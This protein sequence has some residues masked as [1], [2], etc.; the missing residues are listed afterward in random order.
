MG[1][2]LGEG[3]SIGFQNGPETESRPLQPGFPGFSQTSGPVPARCRPVA[4]F[5]SPNSSACDLDWNQVAGSKVLSDVVLSSQRKSECACLSTEPVPHNDEL[6]AEAAGMQALRDADLGFF[7]CI[8]M[9]PSAS[10]A[11]WAVLGFTFSYLRVDISLIRSRWCKDF[12]LM[13]S[14]Y[15][16]L[17]NFPP[18]PKAPP[19]PGEE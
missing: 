10:I 6:P 19:P 16:L 12:P 7:R 13:L 9:L 8:V 11:L 5:N 17:T 15:I 14:K 3:T 18:E 1:Q 4:F 2:K